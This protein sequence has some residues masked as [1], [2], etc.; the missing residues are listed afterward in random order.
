MLQG[1]RFSAR[2]A[3]AAF[4]P[5]SERG[6][7]VNSN[8]FIVLYLCYSIW[9]SKTTSAL[10]S[11]YWWGCPYPITLAL[12]GLKK[13]P[14]GSSFSCPTRN[15]TRIFRTKI[16]RNSLY[17]IGHR[18]NPLAAQKSA[19]QILSRRVFSSSTAKT[20]VFLL[21]KELWR[22]LAV[23]V[24]LNAIPQKRLQK[25]C[26]FLRCA[27]IQWFFSYFFDSTSGKRDFHK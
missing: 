15:R 14:A 1:T 22:P 25:Y 4:L 12:K 18:R 17:T 5:N 9:G 23:R 24:L 3:L 6:V 20:Y 19:I 2:S 10:C 21:I 11:I 16:W 26:F 13:E 7:P 8:V 27:N